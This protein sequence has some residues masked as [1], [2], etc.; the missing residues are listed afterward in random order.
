MKWDEFFDGLK[1]GRPLNA[2]VFT[3]VE[4]YVK[5]EALGALRAALLPQGLEA[6][7]ENVL[8]GA[9]AAKII[10]A[11]ETIPMM[12]DRRLVVV[13]DWAPLLP[14]ASR[15][16]DAE[17]Q[18][19]ESWLDR[20]IKT[21]ILVFFMRGEIDRRKKFAKACIKRDIVVDFPQLSD[22]EIKKWIAAKLRPLSKKMSSRAADQLIFTA[23]RD[24][25]RLD[26]ELSK[27]AAYSAGRAEIDENDIEQIVSPSTEFGAFEMLNRLFDGDIGGAYR[28]LEMMLDKGANRVGILASLTRQ[29]RGL[30][31]MKI[32]SENGG[33]TAEAAGALALS[34][35]AAKVMLQKSRR[36]SS[37]A[38]ETLY[39]AAISAD[40]SIKSGRV[41]DAAALDM[42]FLKIS[43]LTDKK[44]QQLN[45]RVRQS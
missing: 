3:G 15:D 44:S 37:D 36:F 5:R 30:L 20:Q 34:P 2:Y 35:A 14:G 38:L 39:D 24:L 27:L 6:L 22:A 8:E 16:E 10:D 17:S 29:L 43:S 13:R 1:A 21:C 12:C 11:A 9:P 32:A 28:T 42:L 26:G 31:F 4:D 23:G 40:Y 33:N 25:T 18:K 45:A 7:N 19:M 41:R